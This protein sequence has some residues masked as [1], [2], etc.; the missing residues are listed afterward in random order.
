MTDINIIGVDKGSIF[1]NTSKG[2][3][4]LSTVKRLDID[5]IRI[6]AGQLVVKI[7]DSEYLLGEKGNFATDLMKADQINTPILTYGSIAKSF[8][9]NDRIKTNLVLGL[10]IKLYSRNKVRMK[11]LFE[12]KSKTLTI[13]NEDRLIAIK[14]VLVYPEAAAAFNNQREVDGIVFDFGGLSVDIAEFRNGKLEKYST[15][16]MGLLKLYSQI[17]NKINA[18]YDLSVTEW[19]VKN[20]LENGIYIFGQKKDIGAGRII[21]NHISDIIER[22]KLEYDLK[23]ARNIILTGGGS[24]DY[25]DKLKA[26]IPQAK[27]SNN[28]KGDNA[29]G[30]EKVGRTIFGE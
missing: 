14:N 1:T 2:F 11:E 3:E 28:A 16:S 10:P 12:N 13:N 15:Y 29:I 22:F 27:L 30:L 24:E 7:D 26:H 19:E 25:F 8:K 5:D 4:I 17:A 9:D 21:D 18:D 23:R 6:G 20:L